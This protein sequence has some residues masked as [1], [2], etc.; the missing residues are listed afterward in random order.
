MSDSRIPLPATAD[1]CERHGNHSAALLSI[2]QEIQAQAGYVSRQTVA[3]VAGCLNLSRAEVDGVVSFYTDL[4]TTPPARHVV[5]ICRAEACQAS[6]GRAVWDAAVDAAAR[7]RD[8]V[9]VE[10]VYCLGNCA[11]GPSAMSEDRLLGRVDSARVS[12]LVDGFGRE[13]R[14]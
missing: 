4:R 6:G 10:A 2:L 8:A 1:I 13:D 12:A 11:C 7:S 5:K 14:A 9:E 3:E